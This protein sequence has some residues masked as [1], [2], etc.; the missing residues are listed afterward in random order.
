MS[1]GVNPNSDNYSPILSLFLFCFATKIPPKCLWGTH[2]YPAFAI[3]HTG[4][5]SFN[6]F[7]IM[8]SLSKKTPSPHSTI[9]PFQYSNIPTF[10]S[11][12]ISHQSLINL[13]SISHQSLI[14]LSSISHQSLINLLSISYQSLINNSSLT[15]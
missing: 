8:L 4:L 14:N 7:G 1:Y 9:P 12:S 11:N 5:Q 10:Q 2:H 6:P 15:A 3:A 13:S